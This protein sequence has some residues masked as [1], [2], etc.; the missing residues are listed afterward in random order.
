MGVKSKKAITPKSDVSSSSGSSSPEPNQNKTKSTSEVEESSSED[1]SDNESDASSSVESDTAM[2]EKTSKKSSHVSFQTAQSYKPPSG[3]KS[4]KKQ[5]PPSSKSSSLLANLSGKQIYHITAPAFLPLETVEQISLE[6]VMQGQPILKHK[7]AQYG[8]PV[9]SM[10]QNGANE[11]TLLL[12]DPKAQTYSSTSSGNI[13]SYHVQQ[14]VNLPERSETQ[15]KVLEAAK[16]LVKPPRKQP[17]NLKMRF[18]PV[19]SGQAPPETLGSSSESE[20]EEPTF[21]VPKGSEERKR[22][23]QQTDG[24]SAQPSGVPRKKSK[25]QSGTTDDADE[26]EI[27]KKSSKSKDEKKSKKSKK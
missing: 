24:D 8:I 25:K 15:D 17:K 22:K 9:D 1:G 26:K 18:R 14:M 11:K 23:H 3:F 13:Q 6:K 4:A 27:S 5:P 7:G 19:G 2:K 16:K 21:K 20:G 10:Q 12:Y